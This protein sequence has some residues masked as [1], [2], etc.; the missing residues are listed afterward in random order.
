[1]G[2]PG[3]WLRLGGGQGGGGDGGEEVQVEGVLREREL[4]EKRLRRGN[5]FPKQSDE[6]EYTA[7]FQL[8]YPL[9]KQINT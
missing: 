2:I 8:Y 5:T 1:M 6:L 9:S 3:A 7:S 4:I